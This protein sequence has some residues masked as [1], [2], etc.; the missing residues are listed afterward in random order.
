VRVAIA[1]AVVLT[2]YGGLV[3]AGVLRSP[4]APALAGDIELARSNRAGLRVL[5][6]G[7]SMTFANS[8]PSTVRRLAAADGSSRRMFVVQY[9][10][11]GW[12]WA[13]AARDDG[14]RELLHEVRWDVV[15]LQEQSQM[16]SFSP[17][18]Q[19]AETYPAARALAAGVSA[20][21]ARTLLFMTWGHRS[22]DRRNVPGDSY[23]AM[24]A[25]VRDGYRALAEELDADVAPV[26][27][28]WAEAFRRRP[29][30]ALWAPDGSHPSRLGSYLTACVFYAVLAGRPPTS[31]TFTADIAP[32]D[33]RFLQRV[34]ASAVD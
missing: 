28:A 5:F 24:Q 23:A 26:G 2:V 20:A 30:L 10:R 19:R 16:L 27:I 33:A 13:R 17:Y 14:L 29:S 4:F 25:R 31:S 34:A 18:R 32:G 15:V 22:G 9:T 21:G 8:M 6:V 7:N 11:G 3:H 1:L 12:T